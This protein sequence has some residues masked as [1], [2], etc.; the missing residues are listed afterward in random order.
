MRLTAQVI[1]NATTCLNPEGKLTLQLRQLE[2]PYIE[3]LA[4]THN[5][6]NVIDLTNNE[7]IE[8]GNIPSELTNL[9]VLLLSNNRIS[10]IDNSIFEHNN[11]KSLMLMNN[12][13]SSYQENFQ[14]FKN[15]ENLCLNGNPIQ[16]ADNYRLFIIWLIPSLKVLDFSKVKV[17][18]LNEA[19]KLFG[20]TIEQ[21]TELAKS[22]LKSNLIIPPEA[23]S[24][25][26]PQDKSLKTVGSKLSKQEAEE[27]VKKLN[28]ATSIEEVERLESALRRGYL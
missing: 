26:N 23:R 9:E 21:S 14:Q 3:N 2:I 10:Y 6:F 24:T 25:S 27:L 1:N 20:N 22:Y 17:S 13:I 11:I 19:K 18:E 28:S 7:L 4:L 5:K 16:K 8:L 15:L 12:N